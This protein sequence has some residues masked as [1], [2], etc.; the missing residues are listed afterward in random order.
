MLAAQTRAGGPMTQPAERDGRLFYLLALYAALDQAVL[1]DP[2]IAGI[3]EGYLPGSTGENNQRG[4]SVNLEQSFHFEFPD[5]NE[6]LTALLGIQNL[7][8]SQLSRLVYVLGSLMH[9][10]EGRVGIA[11]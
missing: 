3:V 5:V 9:L 2:N 6:A 8:P 7:T 10:P 1:G 4:W 11:N